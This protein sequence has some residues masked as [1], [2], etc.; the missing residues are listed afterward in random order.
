M[1][2]KKIIIPIVIVLVVLA[3]LGGSFAFLWFKTDVFNFMKPSNEVFENQVEKALN[4][5]NAKFANYSDF[6]NRY[7]KVEGKS[8][9]SKVNVSA[10]LNISELDS[11][12]Q[13]IINKSKITIEN[14]VD[15][16]NKSAQSKLGLSS[17]N[18]D[19][20]TLEVIQNEG[21]F[22]I[23]CKD[24]YDK[25]IS[26]SEKD[27][28]S[29]MKE[30]SDLSNDDADILSKS[31]SGTSIS[32]Y[33]LLYISEDDLKHFDDTYG[34]ILT[35]LVSKDNYT[36]KKDVEV[37]VDGDDVKTTAYYLTLT[38]KDAYKFAEDFANLI[39][40]DSTVSKIIT[41]KANMILEQAG[42]DKIDESDVKK[43]MN[44]LFDSLLEE[45]DSMKDEDKSAI[46]IAVYSK[47]NSPVRF[48]VNILDD[49]DDDDSEKLMSIEYAK[50]KDIYTIYNNG[51]SYASLVNEYEK[52]TDDEKVGKLSIKASGMS[53]GTLSYELV[54]KDSESKCNI[55]VNVPLASL[56]A[57][58][59]FE[60]KGDYTKEPVDFNGSFKF[61]YDKESAEVKFDG[62][63]EY[64]DSVSIPKL[65]SSN[66]IDI[67]NLSNDELQT[68]L[69]TI[70]KKASEVLPERLKLIGINVTSEDILNVISNDT[71]SSGNI[72]DDAENVLENSL[73]N[74]NLNSLQDPKTLVEDLEQ[75]KVVID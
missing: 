49:V 2:A 37:E 13:D 72:K 18:S 38:G 24:L 17:S 3:I 5:E 23:G 15:S 65:T 45:L 64:T 32:P 6:L 52:N 54:T 53:I 34:N 66:S 14:N 30:N 57:E 40:D 31:L 51:K 48:E 58:I 29:Y 60:S 28:I 71:T 46:Q 10:N 22:G 1:K 25:Y 26:F 61:N 8:M 73:N 43:A 70:I 12:V 36:S 42:Q 47:N 16:S 55:S 63:F 9:K 44:E 21:K 35:K 75:K 62:S 39:K 41:E 4:I 33:E 74:T 68:E 11:D 50:N 7:K 20:L 59:K 69:T 19:V 56:T 67:M 27:L